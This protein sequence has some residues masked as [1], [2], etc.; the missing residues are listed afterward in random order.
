MS[1]T[2]LTLREKRLERELRDELEDP[3]R[4]V[5]LGV[6]LRVVVQDLENGEEL[7]PGKPAMRVLRVYRFG[8]ILDTAAKPPRLIGPPRW[9]DRTHAVWYCS[10][11]QEA[12]LRHN[13]PKVPGQVIWGSEGAGKSF[14]LA[15]L[16]Y[17]WW[18]ELLGEDR[19]ALQTAPTK[20]RTKVVLE[21]MR[22]LYPPS[23]YTFNKHDQV[24]RFADGHQIRLLSTR[25]QS[26][27]QGAPG[28]GWNASAGGRDELQDQVD[29]HE[30][31][32]SRGRSAKVV[33][34]II[35]FKQAATCTAKESPEF[36]TLVS[37]LLGSGLWA[38]RILLI[39]RSPFVHPSFLEQKK[40]VMTD[41]EF[42]RRYKCE[43]LPPENM[44]YFN[45]NR[46]T[47]LA[48]IP[49]TAKKITSYVLRQKTGNPRHALLAGHDPGTAKAA[50]IFL[51]AYE[52]KGIADPVWWVRGEIFLVHKTCEQ[53]GIA[54]LERARD[55]FN[56]NKR[57]GAELV[58]VRA[59]PFGQSEDKPSLDLYR[60]FRRVGLDVKAAQYKKVRTKTGATATGTGVIKKDDR[61]EMINTLLLDAAGRT[62]L[63]VECDTR[64]EPKAPR[65]VEAFETMERD[66]EGRAETEKKT[67]HDKSDPPA[68]LGYAVWPWEKE[69][70]QTAR[71]QA[72]AAAAAAAE[73]SRR[74]RV[75]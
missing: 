16:H 55:E 68:A 10:E 28:Q 34:N 6:E 24:L 54:I 21:A 65:L 53:N 58:H 25:K 22:Q 8:G 27:A 52:V 61:I 67:L 72:R 33:D 70:A 7:I 2:D 35:Q 66:D 30:D 59:H 12:C 40:L 13:D 5:N 20:V 71:V 43:D 19:M 57:D 44:L 38:K 39:E 14:V 36:R 11:D 29:A 23:W 60:I 26:E 3:D 46:A 37:T 32:E 48:P 41:R 64:G 74:R 31:I 50:T 1:E 49:A 51:D 18:L 9:Q 75:A 73:K 63:Y 45:W 47:N 42:R 15:T 4:F 56:T 69:V 17:L 62:R